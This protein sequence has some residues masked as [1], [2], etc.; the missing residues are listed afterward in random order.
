LNTFPLKGKAKLHQ[1]P[2]TNPRQGHQPD[3]K[4]PIDR[5]KRQYLY[6][7][8]SKA[9][10]FEEEEYSI[11]SQSKKEVNTGD[12]LGSFR[13]GMFGEFTGKNQSNGSLDFAGGDC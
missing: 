9:I 5:R 7:H 10:Y 2:I 6:N 1:Y 3:E 8:D 13:D 4:H 12:S 11:I